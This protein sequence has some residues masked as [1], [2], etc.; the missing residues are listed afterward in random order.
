MVSKRFLLRP[1]KAAAYSTIGR[2]ANNQ[3]AAFYCL[4]KSII[5]GRKLCRFIGVVADGVGGQAK[6]EVASRI[7]TNIIG[8]YLLY[9]LAT[10]N[11][12]LLDPKY[13]KYIIEAAYSTANNEIIKFSQS[14][15]EAT[16]MG[17]TAT[18]V[19]VQERG[20]SIELWVG[21]VGDSRAYLFTEEEIIPLTRDHTPIQEPRKKEIT[22]EKAI[23]H[24]YRKVITKALGTPN[25]KPDFNQHYYR[26]PFFILICSDGLVHE[27]SE[28]EIHSYI[29]Q[30]V[31][32]TGYTDIIKSLCDIALE[33]GE[34]DNITAILSGPFHVSFI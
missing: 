9:S 4:Q 19:V 33:R 32:K 15:P 10:S 3:D 12:E 23:H 2:R 18:T 24:P 16:G 6:G 30:N 7:A 28:R 11:K 26:E 8:A 25:W 13:I 21:H 5:E 14:N 1:I 27:L 34:T 31:S 17:T 22:P 29:M 20:D